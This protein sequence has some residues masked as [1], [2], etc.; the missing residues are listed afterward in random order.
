MI[1]GNVRKVTVEGDLI[2]LRVRGTGVEHYDECD[3]RIQK[4]DRTKWFT[5]AIKEV[6]ISVW[7]Q[8]GKLFAQFGEIGKHKGYQFEKISNSSNHAH[9]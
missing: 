6:A 5:N 2:R 9:I 8:S 7:W 1:G 4:D 3:V